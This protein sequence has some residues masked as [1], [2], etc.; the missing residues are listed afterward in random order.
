MPLKRRHFQLVFSCLTVT[1]FVN[2]SEPKESIPGPRKRLK[3]R[4]LS[5]LFNQRNYNLLNLSQEVVK[6][7]SF[8]LTKRSAFLLRAFNHW[9]RGVSKMGVYK[10]KILQ[11]VSFILQKY[12]RFWKRCDP[13]FPSSSYRERR[14]RRSQ[15]PISK[16]C[17][18]CALSESQRSPAASQGTTTFINILFSLPHRE[19]NC[20]KD[21]KVHFNV[22]QTYFIPEI[23]LDWF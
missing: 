18:H 1:E 15:T 2:V 10:Q 5:L 14:G 19:R 9:V 20:I 7:S 21:D 23:F 12:P 16:T 6:T 8:R 22:L 17:H 4:A 11:E 13:G 3:I